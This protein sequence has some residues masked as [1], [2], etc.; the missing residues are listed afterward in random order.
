MN[1][2]NYEVAFN[3][4][5]IAE[6]LDVKDFFNRYQKAEILFKLKKFDEA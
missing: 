4:V 6:K 2:G 3:C 1:L 5:K